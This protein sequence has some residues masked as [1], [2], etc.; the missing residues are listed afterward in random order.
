MA[1]IALQDCNLQIVHLNMD[2]IRIS[3]KK[4]KVYNENSPNHLQ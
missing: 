2:L 1:S 4:E 3:R